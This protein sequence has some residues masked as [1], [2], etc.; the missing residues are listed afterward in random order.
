MHTQKVCI[1]YF[2]DQLKVCCRCKESKAHSEFS[3]NKS[4]KDGLHSYCKLCKNRDELI[5]FNA[6]PDYVRERARKARLA[7][8]ERYRETSRKYWLS[9][10]NKVRE[11]AAR[12]RKNNPDKVKQNTKSA[13]EKYRQINLSR[14]E[15]YYTNRENRFKICYKCKSNQPLINFLK[16]MTRRDGFQSICNNCRN[17]YRNNRYKTQAQYKLK[18]N[19]RN[20]AH[21]LINLSG[22]IKEQST[23]EL[24]GSNFNEAEKMMFAKI[25]EAGFTIEQLLNGEIEQD[26][27]VP[28]AWFDLTNEDEYREAG[29][30]SNLHYITKEENQKKRDRY[31]HGPNNEIILKE[32]WIKKRQVPT[33]SH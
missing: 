18:C 8:V 22:K 4:R 30:I 10:T 32:E 5:R 6:N 17:E 24:L 33:I 13:R 20:H 31:A 27:K 23:E 19:L 11:K 2:M 16:D 25:K 15:S 28:L 3:K 9:N 12:W 26:H 14:D 29:H 1:N 21:R 7:N